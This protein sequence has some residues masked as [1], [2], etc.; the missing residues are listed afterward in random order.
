MALPD[1]WKGPENSLASSLILHGAIKELEEKY[2]VYA[3]NPEKAEGRQAFRLL[4]AT[5]KELGIPS[6]VARYL[7][8]LGRC[9]ELAPYTFQVSIMQRP[10][11]LRRQKMRKA[12]DERKR[13]NSTTL[14]EQELFFRVLWHRD[15]AGCSLDE[16]I[17]AVASGTAHNLFPNAP[18]LRRSAPTVKRAYLKMRRD[19]KCRGVQQI[20][21]SPG[22]DEQSRIVFLRKRGRP[23]RDHS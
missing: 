9:D 2:K 7:A 10:E 3:S 5:C 22:P 18:L 8:E 6:F 4:L 16:A 23:K 21:L 1:G 13:K 11:N 17:E 12:E 20:E 14:R 19:Y 15:V